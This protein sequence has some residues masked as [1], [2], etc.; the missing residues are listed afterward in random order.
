ML[1]TVLLKEA[2]QLF[3]DKGF[4]L[5]ALIEPIIFIVMFGSSFQGGD[6]NHLDTVV[7]DED[8]TNFSSYVVDATEKSEYFDIVPSSNSLED[9]LVKL[10]NSEIRAILFIPAGFGENLDNSITGEIDMYLD[11][12]NFLTYN[13]LSGAKAEIIGE[14]LKNV[15]SD[16]M[17]DVE[18]E[19]KEGKEKI[20][21]VKNI[22]DEVEFE[23]DILDIELDD[24]KKQT[25]EFNVSELQDFVDETKDSLREKQDCLDNAKNTLELI[26]SEVDNLVVY[27]ESIEL[28]L[29][30]LA[31]LSAIIEN[32]N[33]LSEELEDILDEINN[34]NIPDIEDDNLSEKIE[35]RLD[36]IKNLF[37]DANTIA[38][39]IN[40]D[41]E[42]LEQKFLSE[43]VKLNETPS[44]GPIK[45]FDY[46]GPGILSLIVFFV[47]LMAPVLNV[48]SEKEKNTLYRLSTT[49]VSSVTIF[50]GKFILFIIFGFFEMI[51][52][53]FLAIF[54]YSLRITGSVYDVIIVLF[55]LSCSA[56]SIGLFI[57]SKV[58]SM[59]QALVVVP[60]IVIP[61]FL[62]S[63]SFFPPDI[64]PDFMNHVSKITPMTFSNHAL[65]SIMIK[66][67]AL[68]DIMVDIYALLAFTIVPIILFIW[69]YKRIKY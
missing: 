4:L 20:D 60:L 14:T 64:M 66:G 8:H 29:T 34:L 5:I 1:F 16:I 52:T 69:S 15:T 28:K 58:K 65:N 13:S 9:N 56:I 39:D 40:I 6:I 22:F 47:S 49:P 61:S 24:L 54:L 50:F 27:G 59:Q 12:S 11:S 18:R 51:Y 25:D 53:L 63:H 19:K 17:D 62:I 31:Q 67:F 2:K 55:L 45:Y 36:K 21:K 68:S 30:I 35:Q 33:N 43:P 10:R 38:K 3:S 57:S 37:E 48:I 46:I 42:K 26:T 7:I 23:S 41:F 44:F 32:F